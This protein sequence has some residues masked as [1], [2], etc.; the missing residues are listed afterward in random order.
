MIIFKLS[1][2][3]QGYFTW[4]FI[5]LFVKSKTNICFLASFRHMLHLGICFIQAYA[6]FRQILHLGKCF[7]Q[8]Y[9]S[10]RQMLHLGICFIQAYASFRQQSWLHLD[11]LALF[12]L[13]FK[14]SSFIQEFQLK[15][16]IPA[17]YSTCFNLISYEDKIF[18][19][20]YIIVRDKSLK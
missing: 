16:D 2:L 5:W 18:E 9:A 4:I 15:L 8:A 6:S 3:N 13:S 17:L 12:R 11:F 1:F 10:F 14:N 20:K 7:I 19:D